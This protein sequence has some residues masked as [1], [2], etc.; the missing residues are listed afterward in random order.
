[1]VAHLRTPHLTSIHTS[2]H[3]HIHTSTHPHIQYLSE[4]Q[5]DGREWVGRTVPFKDLP[6]HPP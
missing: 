4:S 5:C 2:T 3:P 1:V 6:G